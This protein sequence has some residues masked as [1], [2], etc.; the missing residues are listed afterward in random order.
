MSSEAQKRS[1]IVRLDDDHGAAAGIAAWCAPRDSVA[2]RRPFMSSWRRLSLRIGGLDGGVGDRL[3]VEPGQDVEVE[4]EVEILAVLRGCA[5]A[6]GGCGCR[7][8]ALHERPRV[9]DIAPD[10]RPCRRLLARSI[11]ARMSSPGES[12]KVESSAFSRLPSRRASHCPAAEPGRCRAEDRGSR[13]PPRPTRV[14]TELAAARRP[15][16]PSPE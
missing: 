10:R 15:A 14:K 8:S 7:R 16:S 1:G 3:V 5:A 2:P 4:V 9:A 6:A 11:W 12:L 13:S